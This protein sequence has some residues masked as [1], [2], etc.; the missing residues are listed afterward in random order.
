MDYV[1]PYRIPN[2][3]WRWLEFWIG[4]NTVLENE[5]LINLTRRAAH[6]IRILENKKLINLPRRAARVHGIFN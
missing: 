1:F 2:A 4:I 3:F 6:V 5:K